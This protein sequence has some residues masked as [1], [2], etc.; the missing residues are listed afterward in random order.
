[1]SKK[2]RTTTQIDYQ[3][4][5]KTVRNYNGGSDGDKV[6]WVFDDVDKD[7]KFA[8]D[9]SAISKDK[10][11]EIIFEKL[12]SYSSM[13]WGEVKKQT[14]DNGKSKHHNLDVSKLSKEAQERIKF[15]CS[16]QN[17]YDS[18]FSFALQ[19]K[20]RIIGIRD[21]YLFHVKWYDP[22]HMFCP[23]NKKRT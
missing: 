12:L 11:L 6:V 5:R 16:E 19:N 23:S 3:P 9:L 15:K 13:T 14:H 22:N 2:K 17:D 7:G 8:F 20:L 4:I 21:K 1:M 10:N 18:I